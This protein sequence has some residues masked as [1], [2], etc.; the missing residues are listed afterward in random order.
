MDG[1]R[2]AGGAQHDAH[3][4]S[5]EPPESNLLVEHRTRSIRREGVPIGARFR[6]RRVNVCRRKNSRHERQCTTERVR[7]VSRTIEPF[8]MTTSNPRNR[9]EWR[10]AQRAFGVIGM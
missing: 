1:R 7:W 4:R 5:I 9:S 6:K 3:G 2:M 8:V 10:E